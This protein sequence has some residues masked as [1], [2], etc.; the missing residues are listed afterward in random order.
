MDAAHA[1]A[2]ELLDHCFS[3]APR[4]FIGQELLNAGRLPEGWADRYLDL[5]RQ[6]ESHFADHPKWPR[7]LVTAVYAASVYC[8]KR[9]RDWL[10]LDPDRARDPQTEAKLQQIRWAGDRLILRWVWKT[11]Q[12]NPAQ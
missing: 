4:G 6:A 2:Q 10:E 8:E 11:E 12:P 7:E 5:L 3:A 1:I 9:Y